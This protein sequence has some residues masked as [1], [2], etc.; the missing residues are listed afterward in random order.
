[1]L[2]HNEVLVVKF[3]DVCYD[4][5]YRFPH[6][7]PDLLAKWILAMR[8]DHWTPKSTDYICS[9]HFEKESLRIYA[10]TV[11]LKE[12]AVPT[13]FSFPAHLQKTVSRRSILKL[14]SAADTASATA[15][16]AQSTTGDIPDPETSAA[17][18]VPVTVH[19]NYATLDSPRG[20]KRKYEQIAQEEHQKRAAVSAKLR[21]VRRQLVRFK[22]RLCTMHDFKTELKRTRDISSE[23]VTLMERCFGD[24]PAELLKRKLKER[25]KDAYSVNLRAFALTLNFYSPKAY[26]FV[27]KSFSNALPHVSTLRRWSSAANGKPGFTEVSFEVK[28]HTV[29]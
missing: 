4:V 15:S 1:M 29:P 17:V 19:H 12:D 3:R 2:I 13:L 14:S 22:A 16:A 27:R 28:Y 11:H 21:N 8:R 5:V 24:I 6:S 9:V 18:A 10:Q 23:A 25:S 7:K 20:V 26:E